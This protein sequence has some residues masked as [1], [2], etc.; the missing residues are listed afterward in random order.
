MPAFDPSTAPVLHDANAHRFAI[1]LGDDACELDYNLRND[2][3]VIYHTGVP[4]PYERRG[5]AARLTRAACDYA[6]ANNLKIEPRCPYTAAF[7]RRYP[8]Y[9]DLLAPGRGQ[10]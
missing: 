10:L 3:M 6:R 4:Q 9:A 8:Q 7:M 1:Q 5:L 2:V